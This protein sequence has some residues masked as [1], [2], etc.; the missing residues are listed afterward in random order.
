MSTRRVEERDHGLSALEAVGC[1][2]TVRDILRGEA[3]LNRP[4]NIMYSSSS[5]VS[6]MRIVQYSPTGFLGQLDF[7]R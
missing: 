5:R 1:P 2:G 3:L 7:F 6:P 4:C